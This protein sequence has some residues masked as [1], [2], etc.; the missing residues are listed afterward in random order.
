VSTQTK[1]AVSNR[2]FLDTL[3]KSIPFAHGLLVTTVPRGDL[4]VAQPANAPET[5]LR[6]YVSGLHQDDVITWQSILQ[7]KVLRPADVWA[8]DAFERSAY[9]RDLLEPLGLTYVAVAPLKAPVLDGYP[10][11]VHLFRTREQGDFTAAELEQLDELVRSV[12][13]TLVQSRGARRA[14]CRPRP[15]RSSGRRRT[16]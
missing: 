2:N 3:K 5:L 9:R 11:A 16:W 7:D 8:A 13:E 15:Q 6:A 1:E 14:G 10:G 12:D 4:Q